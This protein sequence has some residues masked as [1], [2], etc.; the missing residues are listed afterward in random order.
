M[1]WPLSSQ[2]SPEVYGLIYFL[3]SEVKKGYFPENSLLS[4][5][6]FNIFISDQDTRTEDALSKSA[7]DIKL[8]GMLIS[9][10][11]RLGCCSD[12]PQ[13]SIGI[14]QQEPPRC[15][16]KT[17]VKSCIWKKQPCASVQAEW[18]CSN[19]VVKNQGVLV[20]SKLNVSQ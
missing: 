10:R 19:S 8:V 13:K 16:A 2:R 6:K 18:M 20:D 1:I 17:N 3:D 7:D 11:A 15:C 9:W 4:L 14:G 5:I 12:G